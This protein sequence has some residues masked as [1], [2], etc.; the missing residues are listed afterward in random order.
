MMGE[1]L[2]FRASCRL[3]VEADAISDVAEP[4]NSVS[5]LFGCLEW[6]LFVMRIRQT[7]INSK[8]MAY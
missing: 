4:D 8:S 3:G 7:V 5:M 2:A 1:R 6:F